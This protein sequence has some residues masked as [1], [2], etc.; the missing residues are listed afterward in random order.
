MIK[1]IYLLIKATL[2][3]FSDEFLRLFLVFVLITHFETHF[4]D[5]QQSSHERSDIK[6]KGNV[7]FGQRHKLQKSKHED[8]ILHLSARCWCATRN[9][10]GFPANHLAARRRRIDR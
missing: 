7:R 3:T 4:H 8:E 6:E 1:N 2:I 10:D 9:H 5:Q